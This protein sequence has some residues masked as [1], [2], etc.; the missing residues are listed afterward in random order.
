M[1]ARRARHRLRDRAHAADGVA[2]HALLA[3]HLAEC[4]VQHHIGRAGRVGAGVVADDGVEAEQRLHQIVFKTF[5]QHLASGAREQVEQAALLIQRELAQ[6]AGGAHR[7]ESLANGADAKSLDD[8]RRRAQHELP[9]HVGNGL[10]LARERIDRGRI[11]LAELCHRLPGAA[12]AGQEI[13]AVGRGQEVLRAA[14]DDAQAVFGK[15]QVGNDLRVEQ[16]DGV[17]RH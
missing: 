11:V 13:A 8:I 16:A 6:D 3:V 12:L 14:L 15:L 4:V 17:G 1:P 5:V 2:P 9:Q 7:V 10:Q